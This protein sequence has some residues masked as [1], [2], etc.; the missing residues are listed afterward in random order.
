MLD[1][2]DIPQRN[3]SQKLELSKTKSNLTVHT[4]GRSTAKDQSEDQNPVIIVA[5]ED[6]LAEIDEIV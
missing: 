3:N 5:S 6:Q 1:I 2:P 4:V